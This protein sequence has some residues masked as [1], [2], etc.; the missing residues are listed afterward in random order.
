MFSLSQARNQQGLL[1]AGF[2]LGLLFD[3]TDGGNMIL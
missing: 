3:H 1:H 2:W